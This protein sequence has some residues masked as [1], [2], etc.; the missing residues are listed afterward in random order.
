MSFSPL[1]DHDDV[2]VAVAVEVGDG[3]RAGGLDSLAPPL[4]EALG[5]AVLD[6]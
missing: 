6:R 4:D 5:L 3:D 2:G 1:I